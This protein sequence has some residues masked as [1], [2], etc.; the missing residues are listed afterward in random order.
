MMRGGPP[1]CKGRLCGM[2]STASSTA[3]TYD[4]LDRAAQATQT[5]GIAYPTKYAYNL[6]DGVTSVEFPGSTV[7]LPRK[8]SYQ[9]DPAGRVIAVYRGEMGSADKYVQSVTTN[10]NK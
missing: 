9:Y 7:T 3:Y 1:S 6:A 4:E 2:A 5:T 10:S 8:V